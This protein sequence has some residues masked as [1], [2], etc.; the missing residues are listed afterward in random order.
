M[1]IPLPDAPKSR[2][3]I[4]RLIGERWIHLVEGSV[5]EHEEDAR[6]VLEALNVS[7][8]DAELNYYF[9]MQAKQN[10]RCPT[11][12]LIALFYT[13]HQDTPPPQTGGRDEV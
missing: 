13:V 12:E 4:S 1:N 10:G 3:A 11:R 2:W 6:L 7:V 5:C 8:S 9:P